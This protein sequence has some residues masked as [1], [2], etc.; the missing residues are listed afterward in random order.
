M[1]SG[2]RVGEGTV[3]GAGDGLA[4]DCAHATA[5]EGVLHDGEDDRMRAEVANGIDD[6][7]VEACL[8]AGFGE[9]VLVALEVSEVEGIG[10]TELEIDELIAGL[11]EV[12]DAA[13]GVDAVVVARIWGRPAGWPRYR[14]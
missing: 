2:W 6:G 1:M 12:F 11:E 14:P 10:G 8:L 13:A 5:D 4:D 9:A 3:D 7:V